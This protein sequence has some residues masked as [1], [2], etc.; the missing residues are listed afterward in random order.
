MPIN[1]LME[2][3]KSVFLALSLSHPKASGEAKPSGKCLLQATLC[4]CWKYLSL[5]IEK[6]ETI[7]YPPAILRSI[8]VAC[9]GSLLACS[10]LPQPMQSCSLTM[11]EKSAEQKAIPFIYSGSCWSGRHERGGEAVTVR[12]QRNTHRLP[13]HSRSQLQAGRSTLPAQTEQMLLLNSLS[14]VFVQG[15]LQVG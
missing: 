12:T 14:P 13:S 10:I 5:N 8:C 7:F 4:Y 6:N 9:W 3:I 1:L 15:Q 11:Q 2:W